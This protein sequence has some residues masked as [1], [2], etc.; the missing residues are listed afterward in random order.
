VNTLKRQRA[1]RWLSGSGI[2][3]GA[4]DTPL[5]VPAGVD[6]RYVDRVPTEQLHEQYKE[7]PDADFVPVSIVGDAQDLSALADSSVDFVIA[8]HLLEHLE[9]PI[10]GLREMLRVIR[11]GG[12]LYMALPDPRVTF[13]VDREL[14]SVDHVVDE[15][16]RG[17][18]HTREAHFAEWV[19]KAEKHV[20]WMRKAGVGTGPD[21]VRELMDLDYSI[22]FHVWRPDTFLEF[23]VAATREAGLEMEM[24]EFIPRQQGDDEYIFVFLKGIAPVDLAVPPLPEERAAEQLHSEVAVLRAEVARLAMD[25]EQLAAVTASRSWRVTAPLR[26]AG[27]AAARLRHR[28]R[29]GAER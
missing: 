14:T 12:V 27:V 21:R 6:V 9:N 16:R 3:I 2:E 13:D 17:T 4:L 8:N 25:A 10:A 22:H 5:A 24:V 7:L 11:P 20:E 18:S 1:A 29:A 26:A 15:Y 28:V 23:L 19:E